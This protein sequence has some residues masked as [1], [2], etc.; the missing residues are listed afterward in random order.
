MVDFTE[1]EL[2]EQERALEAEAVGL[3]VARY[4]RM[5]ERG[6]ERT[7]P[8]RTLIRKMIPPMAEAVQQWVESAHAGKA[9]NQAGLALFVGQFAPE[10]VAF[11]VCRHALASFAGERKLARTAMTLTQQLEE[12]SMSDA[13][14]AADPKAFARLQ[15]KIEKSPWPNKRFVLVR[16]AL[17]AANVKRISWGLSERARLGVYLLEMCAN[18]TGTFTI[19]EE[20]RGKQTV[21]F[22]IP[23]QETLEWL[24]ESHE[25]CSLLAPRWLPMVVPPRPWKGLRDGGYLDTR[26]MRRWIISSNRPLKRGYI[27]ELKN[28]DLS[29]VYAALNAV[30]ATPWRINIGVLN[31]VREIWDSGG[32]LGKLPARDDL[33]IPQ[34]PWGD[35]EAPTQDAMNAHKANK[36]R[37]LSINER[38][39]SKRIAMTQKLWVAEKFDQFSAIYFPHVLDWRGRI[40][41]MASEV[42]PQAD[43]S[44]RALLEFANGARLGDEGA[45]W[46]AVHGANCFGVDKVSFDDRVKWVE[47][48]QDAILESALKPTEGVRW[49]AQA[50]DPYLFLA[51]CMEWAGL[52]SWVATEGNTQEDFISHLPVSWD[53]SCNGLQNFSAMLRDEIGGEATNLIPSDVPADI[54]QKVADV[55]SEQVERD[56]AAGEVNA[57]YWRGKVTRK[58]AKRPTMTLPYGSGRYGFRDQIRG[59]LQR[60]KM[61]TG[62]SYVNGDEFLCSMYLANVMYDSL[63]KVVVAALSAMD[64]LRKVSSVAAKEG[65]P[66]WWTAPSGFTVMQEY[67]Q[68]IGQRVSCFVGGRR[69]TIVLRIESEEIDIRKQAQGISPNFV[70]SLDAAHLIRTVV[71]CAEMGVGSFAMVHDSYGTHAG[72]AAVLR[73]VLRECFVE[74]YSGDVLADFKKELLGQV[75]EKHQKDIPPLPPMGNLEL[76]GVRTSEYF[77][78]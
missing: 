66:V 1:S 71:R 3:G 54:Y 38:L 72:N 65:L 14:R 50:E 69:I 49:W 75:S 21:L 77:F 33:P 29:Q 53:G 22:L 13:L 39:V 16:K 57:V 34:A 12:A 36:G 8:G 41:P 68:L 40:Y 10:D 35:G 47:D 37:T 48:N 55:A 19:E 15:T 74:Q 70:H 56:A 4:Y 5:V 64:W 62:V 9:G 26:G 67:R 45:F 43:D 18:V 31:V 58:I 78:A 61:D 7:L 32:M 28:S 76:S 6:E 24:Q 59:E 23:K 73:D 51:F 25:R 27:E 17:H 11:V 42:N 30:Q 46:L 63:G 60:I 44:G 2:F 52:M 20:W